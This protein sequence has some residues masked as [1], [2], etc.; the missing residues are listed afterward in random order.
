MRGSKLSLGIREEE[1]C[2]AYSAGSANT[3][4]PVAPAIESMSARPNG[5][6]GVLYEIGV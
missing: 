2:A 1:L 5:G 4:Q 3:D 6:I